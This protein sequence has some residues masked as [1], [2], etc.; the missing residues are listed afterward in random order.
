[1][2]LNETAIKEIL[3]LVKGLKFGEIIIKVQDS[4]IVSVEKREKIRLKSADPGD[5][6]AKFNS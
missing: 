2:S 3:P 6:E 4:H 5:R 1:M